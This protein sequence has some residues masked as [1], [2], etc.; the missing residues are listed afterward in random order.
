MGQT[1]SPRLVTPLLAMLANDAA[2][3]AVAR[4]PLEELFG[5]VELQSQL[6]AFNKTEYYDASMGKGL[7][8]QFFTFKRLADPAGLVDWKLTT[9]RLEVE[10][11][12]IL[13]SQNPAAASIDRPINLDP[14]Y[15][16]GAKLVLASTKDFAH[17]IYLRDG[18]F[19]EITMGF[20][21]DSW[22]SHDFTFPDFRSGMYDDFLKKARDW[23]LRKVK[24]EPKPPSDEFV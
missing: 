17:R 22:V 24:N 1:H 13:S 15:L 21:G 5:P 7:Q 3:F 11:K 19:A 6:Y 12:A 2:S 8:R 23:H 18:I 14:G 9:N 20:R 4:K 10:L 16:T